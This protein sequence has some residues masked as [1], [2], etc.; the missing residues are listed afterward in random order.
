MSVPTPVQSAYSKDMPPAF[1][2]MPGDLRPSDDISA[3]DAGED[4]QFGKFLIFGA[5]ADTALI[6]NV[7]V[8]AFNALGV[9]L[10]TATIENAPR[11]F[12]TSGVDGYPAGKNI[13]VRRKGTVWMEV[14]GAFNHLTDTPYIRFTAN[15]ALEPG[16]IA[17]TT[18][19]GKAAAAPEGFRVLSSTTGAG[20]VLCELNLP[21]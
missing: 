2:G 21:A 14:E 9:A 17:L 1:K 13:S 10:R 19:S 4:V 11:G 15:S 20:F 12:E 8:T 7:A 6:P 18:D 3:V 16:N 5:A